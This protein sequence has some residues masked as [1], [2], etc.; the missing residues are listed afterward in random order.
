MQGARNENSRQH[1]CREFALKGVPFGPTAAPRGLLSL[2]TDGSTTFATSSR[3]VLDRPRWGL[4]S[5]AAN[6]SPTDVQV[7]IRWAACASAAPI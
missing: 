3:P 7:F 5:T 6:V 1:C 2:E 4:T